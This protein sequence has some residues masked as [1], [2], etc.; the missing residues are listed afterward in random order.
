M[1]PLTEPAAELLLADRAF[2]LGL[3]GFVGL[4]VDLLLDEPGLPASPAGPRQRTPLRHGFLSARSPRILVVSG[5]PSPGMDVCAERM[6]EDLAMPLTQTTPP[7]D[8][9]HQTA[10]HWAAEHQDTGPRVD[11]LCAAEHQDTGHQTAEHWATEHQNTRPWVD[12]LCAAGHRVD[13]HRV[14][15]H[16]DTGHRVAVLAEAADSVDPVTADGD[17]F[18]T[19]TAGIRVA[20]EAGTDDDGPFGLR[21][22]WQLA[23][24]IAPVLAAAFANAPL[25]HGRPTG[26][27]STRQ[28][29]RRELPSAPAGPDPRAAWTALVMDAPVAGTGRTLRAWSRSGPGDR[30]TV[31]DLSRHLAD[32]R[33]PVAARRHLELDVADRQPGNGWRVPLAVITVLM[34]D[35]RAAA[36]AEAAARALAAAPRLWERARATRSPTPC[37]PPPLGSASS[38]RTRPWPAGVPPATCA[39]R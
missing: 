39:T 19:A 15:G 26:W 4:A 33:P 6:A 17:T 3:P 31:A 32:L 11:G 8:A 5:P 12:G 28:A 27:R 25:R 23:H 30:P 18:G 7:R 10:E 13:G 36:E 9:E 29:L 21:R 35:P 37:W 34:D 24:A 22:R 1:P 16:R 14:D 2:T 38:P 20:L